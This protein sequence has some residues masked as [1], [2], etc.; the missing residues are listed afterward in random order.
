M[1]MK[2]VCLME[3]SWIFLS[4][5]LRKA[6]RPIGVAYCL[7]IN[8]ATAKLID[9]EMVWHDL[10]WYTNECGDVWIAMDKSKSFENHVCDE[11]NKIPDATNKIRR[12]MQMREDKM[13]IP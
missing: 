8:G 9:R 3:K 12:P 10:R 13:A 2:A 6:G 11:V 7:R 5:G 4:A 1:L